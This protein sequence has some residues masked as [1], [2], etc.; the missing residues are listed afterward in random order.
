MWIVRVMVQSMTKEDDVAG[1]FSGK[2]HLGCS[3]M[4]YSLL[5]PLFHRP[6]NM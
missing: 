4:L 3:P 1:V 2:Q 5:L 6:S